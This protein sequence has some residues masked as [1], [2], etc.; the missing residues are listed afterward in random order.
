MCSHQNHLTEAILMG[1]HNI[2][3]SILRKEITLN[4]TKSMAK[5]FFPRDTRT[6]S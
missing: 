2:S 5:G 1:T 4:Y 6:S 3:F